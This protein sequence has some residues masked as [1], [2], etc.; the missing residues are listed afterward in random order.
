MLNDFKAIGR[1][2]KEIELRKTPSNKSYTKFTLAVDRAKTAEGE[3]ITDFINFQAWDKRAETL[4]KYLF[5]GDM[6]FMEGELIPQTYDDSNGV[7]HYSY[8][9]NVNGFTLLPNKR[10]EQKTTEQPVEKANSTIYLNN[11]VTIEQDELP[12]Y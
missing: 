7:K 5:K 11:G 9:V 1:L 12:F 8:V 2:T 10:E 4:Q 3:T 6:I